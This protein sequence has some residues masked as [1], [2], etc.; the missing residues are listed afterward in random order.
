[1]ASSS[2][3]EIE[4]ADEDPALVVEA[5]DE[6]SCFQEAPS[7]RESPQSLGVRWRRPALGLDNFS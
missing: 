1:M 3:N 4:N 2:F 5:S 6:G 7:R